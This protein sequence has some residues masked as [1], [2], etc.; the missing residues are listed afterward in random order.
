M[1]ANIIE[2]N[3]QKEFTSENRPK[4]IKKTQL[5]KKTV[6]SEEEKMIN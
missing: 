6:L 5:G 2:G 3:I 4:I 1:K